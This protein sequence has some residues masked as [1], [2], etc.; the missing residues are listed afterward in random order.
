MLKYPI[1]TV[2]D[3]LLSDSRKLSTF[4]TTT[5]L[6]WAQWNIQSTL[7]DALLRVYFF[8]TNTCFILSEWAGSLFSLELLLVHLRMISNLFQLW[9]QHTS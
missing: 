4:N 1:A 2:L 8:A 6:V 7:T 5:I 3:N 9:L